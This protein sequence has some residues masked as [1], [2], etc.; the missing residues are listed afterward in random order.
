MA[1]TGS[2]GRAVENLEKRVPFPNRHIPVVSG[3]VIVQPKEVLHDSSI[4]W[5][6]RMESSLPGV[7]GTGTAHVAH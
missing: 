4:Q 3:I 7:S 5:M 6:K 2:T 1:I